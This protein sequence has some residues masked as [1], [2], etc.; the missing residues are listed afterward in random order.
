MGNPEG[1]RPQGRSRRKWVDIIKMDIR[2]IRWGVMDWIHLSQD[3]D[4]WFALLNTLM[5][6]RVQ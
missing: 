6:I 4:Q 5:N 2:E 3:S 1:K